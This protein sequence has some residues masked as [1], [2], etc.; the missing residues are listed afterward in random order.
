MR[1]DGPF[2]R[3]LMLLQALLIAL[4]LAMQPPCTGACS[5]TRM[6][7]PSIGPQSGRP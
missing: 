6:P 1:D 2:A 5:D 3:I 7:P 4:I